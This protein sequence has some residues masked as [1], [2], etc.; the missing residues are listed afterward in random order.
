MLE[1][2]DK[3]NLPKFGCVLYFVAFFCRYSD[4]VVNHPFV[5]LCVDIILVAVS[6]LLL[7]SLH[8]LPGIT[9]PLTVS[10]IMNFIKHNKI[11]VILLKVVILEVCV[12]FE[13]QEIIFF[14]CNTFVQDCFCFVFFS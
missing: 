5:V 11:T 1:L 8:G 10:N 12:F 13:D 9:H 2:L 3:L 14:V 7:T 6:I 4:F